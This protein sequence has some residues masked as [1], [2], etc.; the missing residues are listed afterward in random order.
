M[1]EIA[2]ALSEQAKVLILDEPTSALSAVEVDKLMRILRIRRVGRH[3]HEEEGLIR[4]GI[5]CPPS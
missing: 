3:F 5:R 4:V 2:K 1:T